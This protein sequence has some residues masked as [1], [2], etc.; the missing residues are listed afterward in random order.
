MPKKK[1]KENVITQEFPIT[2]PSLITQ[3]KRKKERKSKN[4]APSVERC[5]VY[6]RGRTKIRQCKPSTLNQIP[7][8]TGEIEKKKAKSN[9]AIAISSVGSMID[10]TIQAISSFTDCEI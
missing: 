5:L 3:Y 8:H 10:A 9:T 6:E 7:S 1:T 2:H 4:K